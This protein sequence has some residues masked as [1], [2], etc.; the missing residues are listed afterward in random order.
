MGTDKTFSASGQTFKTLKFG[1]SYSYDIVFSNNFSIDENLEIN[2]V[3]LKGTSVITVIGDLKFNTSYATLYDSTIEINVAGDLYLTRG[4]LRSGKIILSGD[5]I[6][7][8]TWDATGGH[9]TIE[10]NKTGDETLSSDY[11]F[12][13]IKFN[14]ARTVTL[15]STLKAQRIYVSEGATLNTDNNSLYVRYLNIADHWLG[16]VNYGIS[17]LYQQSNGLSQ[18]LYLGSSVFEE[19]EM[20]NSS[21]WESPLNGGE[22]KI[23]TQNG[24]RLLFENSPKVTQTLTLISGSVSSGTVVLTGYLDCKTTFTNTTMTGCTI[25]WQQSG[26]ITWNDTGGGVGKLP[27]IKFNSNRTVTMGNHIDTR[28][29][30][31]VDGTLDVSENNYDISFFYKA[32]E[33]MH[34]IIDASSNVSENPLNARNGT[35]TSYNTTTRLKG[36]AN[37]HFYNLTYD[38]S[39]TFTNIFTNTVNVDNDM[40]YLTRSDM[41]FSGAT[42]NVGRDLVC[43]SSTRKA[44]LRCWSLTGTINVGRDLLL[45][46]AMWNVYGTGA[47]MM[48]NISG[49]ITMINVISNGINNIA[50]AHITMNGT[51][52]QTFSA[53]A[54]SLLPD[55]TVNKTSGKAIISD[56]GDYLRGT[57]VSQGIMEFSAGKTFSFQTGMSNSVA[58]GATM[59]FLGTEDDPIILREKDDGAS[60]WPIANA[61]G[62]TITAYHADIKNSVVENPSATAYDSDDSGGNVNWL[63]EYT[64]VAGGGVIDTPITDRN[65]IDR[66]ILN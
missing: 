17:K 2:Q 45:D 25:D 62:S 52:D 54:T 24:S 10:W 12:P 49:N 55:I 57:T 38:V 33:V 29:L 15:G 3:D 47:N 5:I 56:G 13:I 34:N 1:A 30:I 11:W 8:E 32:G 64:V 39:S 6:F 9:T 66:Q 58:S 14:S 59:T 35:V 63:W 46:N 22:M 41:E 37:L 7:A 23:L 44:I 48:L 53:D 42:I 18:G 65:I 21:S 43:G 31:F 16:T 4:V 40:T 28:G 19:I 36:H 26:D 50:Y 27:Y 20:I 60:T 51:T 61:A